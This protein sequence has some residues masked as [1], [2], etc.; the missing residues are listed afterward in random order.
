MVQYVDVKR[1]ATTVGT[2]FPVI[3]CWKDVASNVANKA[4]HEDYTT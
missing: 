2:V 1:S 4:N 3:L